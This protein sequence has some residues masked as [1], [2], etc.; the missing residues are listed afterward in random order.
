[1]RWLIPYFWE[2]PL[3][4]ARSIGYLESTFCCKIKKTWRVLY[5]KKIYITRENALS[6]MHFLKTLLLI[7][8]AHIFIYIHVLQ[9][10]IK[11]QFYPPDGTSLDFPWDLF[12]ILKPFSKG[13][14][15]S[16]GQNLHYSSA[17]LLYFHTRG[18]FT[19]WV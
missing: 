1:M 8:I 2:K 11:M 3:S 17:M 15:P 14:W 19:T 9:F 4:E 18:P 6:K 16:G 12:K 5:K 10:Q 7:S 13:G